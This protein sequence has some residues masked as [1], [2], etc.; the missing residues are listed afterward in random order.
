MSIELAS[1][2]VT[3]IL[4]VCGVII[5]AILSKDKAKKWDGR[6]RRMDEPERV[7]CMAHSGLVSSLEFLKKSNEQILIDINEIKSNLMKLLIKEGLKQ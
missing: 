4:G 2:F 3:G 6:E 5:A 7:E 1:V